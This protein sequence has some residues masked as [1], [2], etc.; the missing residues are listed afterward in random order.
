MARTAPVPNIPPIPGMCPSI[1]VMGG[2]SGGGGGTGGGSGEGDGSG[3]AD[4]DGRG[5]GADGDGRDACGSSGADGC[6]NHHNASGDAA[7][8]DPV[9]VAT[10]R[11]FTVPS[12][13]VDLPGPLPLRFVRSYSTSAARRDVGLGFGWSHSFAW[14]IELGRLEGRLWTGAATAVLFD[15]IEPGATAIGPNG[16]I[17]HRATTGFVVE[18]NDGLVRQFCPG[19]DEDHFVLTRVSDGYGNAIVMQYDGQHRLVGVTDAVGRHVAVE[20]AAD[21]HIQKLVGK[22]LVPGKDHLFVQYTHD[23]H[24]DLVAA[25]QAAR[26]PFHYSYD[27]RHLMTS[28]ERNDGVSFRYVYDNARRCLETWADR[29]DGKLGLAASLPGVLNDG[30]TAARGVHHCKFEYSPRCVQV[31]DSVKAQVFHL[32]EY[33]KIAKTVSAGRVFTRTYDA[34]GNV[35][36]FEDAMGATTRWD[37]DGR[38]RVLRVTDPLGRSKRYV[39]TPSGAI[40]REIDQ[41]GHETVLHGLPDG[42]AWVDALNARFVVKQDRAG[43]PTELHAPDGSVSRCQYDAQGNLAR[44][45]CADGSVEDT[46]YDWRGNATRIRD[47]DGTVTQRGFDEQGALLWETTADGATAHY[48]YDLAGQLVAK[49]SPNGS[50]T[51][52]EYGGVGRLTCVG[53]PDGSSVRLEYDREGRLLAVADESGRR[54]RY[55]L[56]SNGMVVAETTFDGRTTRFRYD[57]MGRV[58]MRKEGS[59][60]L[61]Y[62]YDAA[63]Q[64]LAKNY[65]DGTTELFSYDAHGN[66]ASMRGPHGTVRYERNALGWIVREEQFSQGRTE[67]V[68]TEWDNIGRV[69]GRRTSLGHELTRAFGA[70]GAP[71]RLGLDGEELTFVVGAKGDTMTI[72][73]P[74]SHV[75]ERAFDGCGRLTLTSVFAKSGSRDERTPGVVTPGSRKAS[76]ELEIGYDSSGAIS[77]RKQRGRKSSSRAFRYDVR[78]RLRS[79]E[80][81]DLSQAFDYD[82]IGNLLPKGEPRRYDDAGRLVELGDRSLAYDNHGQLTSIR[83]T[84]GLTRLHWSARGLCDRIDLPDG[85]SVHSTYDALARRMTKT[86]RARGSKTVLERTRYVWSGDELVH[87]IHER[88]GASRDPVIEEKTYAWDSYRG[89]PLGV[90]VQKRGA[91]ADLI[92]SKWTYFVADMLNRPLARVTSAGEVLD[93]ADVDAW[94]RGAPPTVELGAKGQIVDHETGLFYNRYRY[95]DPRAGRY[96]SPDPAGLPGGLNPFSYA[97]NAPSSAVDPLGLMPFTT[98]TRPDGTRVRGRSAG[99]SSPDGGGRIHPNDPAIDTAV[100]NAAH[101]DNFQRRPNAAGNCAEI[102]ALHGLAASIREERRNARPPQ[103]LRNAD[104][105][106]AAIREQLRGEFANGAQMRTSRDARQRD[107]MSPCPFCAQVMRELGLHPQNQER[108]GRPAD[109]VIG[110]DGDSWNGRD[111]AG[112][113]ATNPSRTPVLSE[114]GNGQPPF[115]PPG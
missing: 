80:H 75:I 14:S 90:R 113:R 64:L 53:Y 19:V 84:H 41:E 29:A 44:Y 32:D 79:E 60:S 110:S 78:G 18:T 61:Q 70:S 99:Q 62:E 45:V 73:L 83:D 30:R 24:G 42:I 98:I 39:R 50:V 104:H 91:A 95:Y 52:Y 102:D 3:A 111:T 46:A 101:R 21:G 34:L 33:G 63:G 4:G 48:R 17:L 105:E 23:E 22:Q 26:G 93:E 5:N 47:V 72:E 28:Q 107:L 11:V 8:G 49:V 76:F 2:G 16:W 96:I 27:E 56:A 89:A 88:A 54:H 38:G 31:F 1:A 115:R 15:R 97:G 100:E 92:G 9:D 58:T 35:I 36:S 109:G 12:Y 81:G 106:N 85:R 68:D 37:R 71:V 6:P 10:G 43:R 66:V 57:A 67:R 114:T 59:R 7:R 13:D 40:E 103:T 108:Q 87:Q 94:G 112:Q 20:R 55:E 25:Q 86:V 77:W 65:S 82:V 74:G 51:H 69:V